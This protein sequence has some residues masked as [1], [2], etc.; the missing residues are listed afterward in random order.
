MIKNSGEKM[1]RFAAAVITFVF[2]WAFVGPVCVGLLTL[3]ALATGLVSDISQ[4][5][6]LWTVRTGSLIGTFLGLFFAAQRIR[7]NAPWELTLLRKTVIF[8]CIY[9]VLQAL[10]LL[11]LY[12]VSGGGD[13]GAAGLFVDFVVRFPASILA[14]SKEHLTLHYLGLFISSAFW[15]AVFYFASSYMK[16]KREG[17]EAPSN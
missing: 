11:F 12:A 4:G 9:Y 10:W 2:F 5:A 13:A 7:R 6:S 16:K 14:T 15:A 1:N 3:F 17:P 8:G